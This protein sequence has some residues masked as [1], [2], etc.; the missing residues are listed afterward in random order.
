VD[1]RKQTSDTEP[2]ADSVRTYLRAIGAVPL[3]TREREVELARALE[4]GSKELSRLVLTSP[5]GLA[6]L[7]LLREGVRGGTVQLDD[8]TDDDELGPPDRQRKVMLGRLDRVLRIGRRRGR[9][10]DLEE[11]VTELRIAPAHVERIAARVYLL[12]ERA[13]R[14]EKRERKSERLADVEK[15]AGLSTPD[16]RAL[17]LGMR[18]AA[19][20][21]EKARRELVQ[22]NLRLVVSIAKR[23]VNRG[24]HLLDLIQEGNVGLM[25]AVEKFDHRRGYK[26]STYATWWV[27]QAVTRGL[28]DQARTIRVPVHMH[29]VINRLMRTSRYLVQRL[30]R[31]PQPQELAEKLGVSLDRLAYLQ[32]LGKEPVSLETPVGEDGDST[33]G[34]LMAGNAGPSPQ[35]SMLS[36]D[37]AHHAR[38]LIGTLSPREEKVVRMRFGIGER[39]AHTLEEV[40]DGFGVT[41]ERIRQIEAKALK[42]LRQTPRAQRLRTML[43]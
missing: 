31:E 10:Q 28:S 22:A 20:H 11:A 8:V 3:L 14:C 34:D 5:L 17:A 39:G 43:D 23:Y 26:F 25:R 42:K 37:L 18:R 35:E 13:E 4:D 27:R 32:K 1:N 6:E 24:M 30:G 41:R 9:E 21:A 36:D 16:L 7:E 19:A 38:E 2:S 12:V 29:E 15:E 40:G 33:L